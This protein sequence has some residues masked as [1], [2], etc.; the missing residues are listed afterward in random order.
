LRRE[1]NRPFYEA[2]NIEQSVE[3]EIR[4]DKAYDKKRLVQMYIH[5]LS[6]LTIL[7]SKNSIQCT[8]QDVDPTRKSQKGVS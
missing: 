6:A 8:M 3:F 2:I 4:M 7:D 1:Q 5:L